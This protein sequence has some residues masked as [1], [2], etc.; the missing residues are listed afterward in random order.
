MAHFWHCQHTFLEAVLMAQMTL[1]TT[2]PAY[3]A[4]LIDTCCEFVCKV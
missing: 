1:L 2:F 4:Q 3:L